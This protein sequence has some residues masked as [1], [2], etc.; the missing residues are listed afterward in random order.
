M[1]VGYNS[2]KLTQNFYESSFYLKRIARY[3]QMVS[4]KDLNSL[5]IYCKREPDSLGQRG[6]K[7]QFIR[8]HSL[9]RGDNK[10][11]LLENRADERRSQSSSRLS[12]T[13]WTR[14]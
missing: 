7:G 6:N 5:Y 12:E 3:S 2:I 8:S 13:Q 14:L 9:E 4:L 10:G 1:I 11:L